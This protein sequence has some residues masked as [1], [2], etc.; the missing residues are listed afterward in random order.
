MLLRTGDDLLDCMRGD[1]I[2]L[3]NCC[4]GSAVDVWSVVVLLMFV[5]ALV[6]L[7][8]QIMQIGQT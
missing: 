6:H 3:G 8:I 4:C 5:D 7:N 2:D 1:G